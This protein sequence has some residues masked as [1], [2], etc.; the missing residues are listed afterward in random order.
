MFKSFSRF[1]FVAQL[2]FPYFKFSVRISRMI[3]IRH[4]FYRKRL[5][6]RLHRFNFFLMFVGM[7]IFWL[8]TGDYQ[9]NN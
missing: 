1:I 3:A 7:E 8:K 4:I 9:S 5:R 2:K 6:N